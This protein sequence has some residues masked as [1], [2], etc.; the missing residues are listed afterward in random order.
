MTSSEMVI[1]CILPRPDPRQNYK[2]LGVLQLCQSQ[3]TCQGYELKIDSVVTAQAFF[4]E[5]RGHKQAMGI[6]S[7]VKGEGILTRMQE[8]LSLSS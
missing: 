4:R 7:S 1:S 6:R 3:S 8:W 2:G 5:G